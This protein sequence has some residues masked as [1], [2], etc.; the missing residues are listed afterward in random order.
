M[1]LPSTH[2]PRNPV[3]RSREGGRQSAHTVQ[4]SKPWHR[5]RWLLSSGSPVAGHGWYGEHS[6]PVRSVRQASAVV[7]QIRGFDHWSKSTPPPPPPA[8]SGGGGYRR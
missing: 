6:P 1:S 7:R 5:A 3:P 4:F 8:P 2:P